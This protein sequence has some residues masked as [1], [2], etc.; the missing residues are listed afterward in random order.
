MASA[1][2]YRIPVA[3]LLVALLLLPACDGRSKEQIAQ[4]QAS[5]QTLQ[6]RYDSLS[7]QQQQ[8]AQQAAALKASVDALT[9]ER[10]DLKG[11][12]S[13]A[14]GQVKQLQS[15]VDELARAAAAPAPAAQPVPGAPA[16]ADTA[17]VIAR[18]ESLAADLF[19]DGNYS[20]VNAVLQSACDLGSR[21][22]LT[23]YRLA[24]ASAGVGKYGDAIGWYEKALSALAGRPDAD[25][26]FH[27]K[28][29]N[30][31]GVALAHTGKDTD[32]IA[33]Y[34]K[35]LGIDPSY[36]PALYNLAL[37]YAPNAA[38]R[39][40]AVD[41]LRQYVAHGGARSV[42]ARDLLQKLLAPE[43]GPA[44]KPAAQ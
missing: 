33:A 41:A 19:R 42:S 24:Y 16:P 4:L 5:I 28:C 20:A 11:K 35:A 15:K 18:L 34:T 36:T 7:A 13:D 39:D 44:E 1:I 37:L 12:L 32:A 43:P 10:D 6:A 9:A 8:T 14:R 17:G 30:N 27:K 40:K 22:P 2:V 31:Y 25:P 26:E 3:A 23:F 21:D 29:L 38:D